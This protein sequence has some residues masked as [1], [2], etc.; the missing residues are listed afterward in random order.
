[1]PDNGLSPQVVPYGADQTVYVVVDSIGARGEIE[2]ERTDLET[3]ISDL[4]GGQFS[5]PLRVVAFNTLEHW[6]ED[7]SKQVADELLVICDIEGIPVP[8]Y[9]ND[10]V[11]GHTGREQQS[12]LCG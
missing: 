10:F 7:I 1:M 11:A 3:V 6:S 12:V 8:E 9:I 4:L 2:V 5:G